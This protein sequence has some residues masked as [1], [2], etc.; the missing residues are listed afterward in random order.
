[1]TWKRGNGRN[2]P[3]VT[4]GLVDVGHRRDDVPD[5]LTRRAGEPGRPPRRVRWAGCCWP[6]ATFSDG[7]HDL[8]DVTLAH[9]ERC[10]AVG[11]WPVKVRGCGRS[12]A[13]VHRSGTTKT[14]AQLVAR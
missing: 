2:D 13:I 12:L 9:A 1:V 8:A 6:S 5:E 11:T 7:E 4:H 3:R 14:A 10:G